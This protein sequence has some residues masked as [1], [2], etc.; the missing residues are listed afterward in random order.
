MTIFSAVALAFTAS[1]APVAAPHV[2]VGRDRY[3]ITLRRSDLHP[4]T[5]AAA[6][7]ALLKFDRAAMA[8]CAAS[9]VSLHELRR[10][11]RR[12]AC[13]RSVIADIR[14]RIDDPLLVQAWPP[15]SR[16]SDRP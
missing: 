13:W 12:S 3:A 6:R 10:A 9:D 1:T 5:P 2:L 14:R 11:V 8:V 15:R 4:V 16:S 7:Q